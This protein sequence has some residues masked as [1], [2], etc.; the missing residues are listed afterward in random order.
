[1]WFGS[2]IRSSA[3]KGDPGAPIV[4]GLIGQVAV[5]GRLR[6]YA[7]TVG[8]PMKSWSESPGKTE[9]GKVVIDVQAAVATVYTLQDLEYRTWKFCSRNSPRKWHLRGELDIFRDEVHRALLFESGHLA[10]AFFDYIALTATGEARHANARCTHHWAG[11]NNNE[12]RRAGAWQRARSF[13]PRTLLSA[14]EQLFSLEWCGGHYGGWAWRRIAE[15]GVRYKTMPD[16]AFLD[17]AVDLSHNS[18]LFLDKGIIFNPPNAGAYKRMLTLKTAHG[19]L[20][21]YAARM[22][23]AYQIHEGARALVLWARE[24]GIHKCRTYWAPE[25]DYEQEVIAWGGFPFTPE[26]VARGDDIATDGDEDHSDSDSNSDD[27]DSDHSGDG[28]SSDGEDSDE[29]GE[30]GSESEHAD[31]KPDLNTYIPNIAYYFELQNERSS[32]L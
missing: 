3:T 23:T 30:K 29:E 17:V 32:V 9:G 1:M 25:A 7:F 16:I 28:E 27:E 4:A 19:L 22:S 13:N 26:I 5:M 24:R 12:S 20:S 6:N 14:C 8:V 11:W 21:P 10:R 15:I 18:G 31:N 2:S